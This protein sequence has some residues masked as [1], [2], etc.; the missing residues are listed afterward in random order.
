MAALQSDKI[1]F[2]TKIITREKEG[3]YTRIRGSI[4]QEGIAII[5]RLNLTIEHQSP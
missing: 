2:K 5:G 1:D 4:H 3:Q